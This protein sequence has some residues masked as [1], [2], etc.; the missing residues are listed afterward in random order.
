MFGATYRLISMPL[1]EMSL[2]PW[3]CR[4]WEG[5][6]YGSMVKASEDT[7]RFMLKVAAILVV[8]LG[9]TGLESVKVIAADQLKDGI[10]FYVGLCT[11]YYR[12]NLKL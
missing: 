12:I 8:T 11:K 7:G 2:L 3:T 4:A 6:K 9:H 1:E 10:V 5:V